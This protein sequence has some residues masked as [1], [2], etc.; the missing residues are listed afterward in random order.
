MLSNRLADL[1]ERAGEAARAYR[2]GS[3]ASIG[4]YLIAGELL[5]EARGESRRG[6]WGAVLDRAGIAP[7]TSR[8]MMQVPRKVRET[9]ADAAAVHD[10]GGIQ[11]FV[12]GRETDPDEAEKTALSAGNGDPE[13][14]E[15]PALVH[16]SPV[17]G[18]EPRSVQAGAPQYSPREPMTL[19]QWRPRPR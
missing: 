4:A 15:S 18:S 13:P 8:L 6:Q 14:D 7:R 5:S 16:E 19:Y 12:A 9:G 1:A 11:A 3:I 2:R 10:A 17:A